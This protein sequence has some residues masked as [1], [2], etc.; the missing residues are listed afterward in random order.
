MSFSLFFAAVLLSGGAAQEALPLITGGKTAYRIYVDPSA[1]A[2]VRTAANDLKTYFTKTAGVSPEIVA[3]AQIPAAPFISLGYTPAAKTAGLDPSTISNDGYRIVTKG[4]NLFILGPDTPAGTVNRTGGVSN[5]TA[6]GVY[7]F[8]EDYLGVHWLMPGQLG[9]EY[10]PIKALSLP[11]TDRTESSPFNY[12]VVSFRSSGPLEEEWDRRLKLGKVADVSHNHSWIE[13]I[14]RSRFDEHPDWFAQ[15]GGKPLPPT[16]SFYKLETTNPGLV[17]AF[18]EVIIQTF[19]KNPNQRWYSLSPSDG[20]GFSDSPASKALTEKDPE[21]GTSYTPLVIKFYNDVARIVGKEFPDHKLGGYIYGQYRYPPAAGLPKLEPNL[22]LMLVGY[23][24]HYRLYRPGMPELNDQL[25]R[26]WGASA[27]KDGFDLYFYDYP[28]SLMA[29]NAI[30]TPPTP[31]KLGF[32]FS[33]M[34]TNGF[35]GAYIYGNPVWPV[36]GVGNYILAKLFW[37]PDQDANTLFRDYCTMA[38]GA[39]AAP[40]IEQLYAALDAAYNRFYVQHPKAGSALTLDHLK[41]IYARLYPE[42]EGH[43]LAAAAIKKEPKHRQRLELFGQVLSLLQWDLREY[44]LLSA[45]YKSPLTRSADDIDGLLSTEHPDFQ[46]TRGTFTGPKTPKVEEPTGLAEA[47]AQKASLVPIHRN[48]NLLLHVRKS[49][50]VAVTV[51]AFNGNNEFIRY[52]LTGPDGEKIRVGVVA[53]GRTIRFRGE[54]GKDYFFSF[55]SRGA[56]AKL[57]VEGASIAYKAGGTGLQ[58]EGRFMDE[59]LPLYFYVPPGTGSFYVTLGTRGA[60]A[61]IVSPDGRQAG[62]LS[63]QSRQV[64]P[65]SEAKSGFW[66]VVFQKGGSGAIEFA[67]DERLPQWFIPDPSHPLKISSVE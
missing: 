33:H 61:E 47:G 58:I 27:R 50:E 46:I 4:K 42:I 22:A 54:A 37:R 32:I 3:T 43:Y 16:G 41:E 55:G 36:S 64:I 26:S 56:S 62:R 23:T 45:D 40:Q 63:D 14:P 21:G 2:S 38:Y 34:A 49:G 12:R 13:T 66:K 15:A 59:D 11:A 39:Q 6:N 35:K 57:A 29:P 52:L 25:M 5:G 51:K 9:E 60:T 65:M 53:K 1:P 30:I 44:G 7:A 24:H 8:I 67:M 31:D 17:A 10:A 28:I 19:R 18:A 48:M 20:S